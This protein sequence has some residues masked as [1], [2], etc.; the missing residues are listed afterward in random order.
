[1]DLNA[2]S[3]IFDKVTVFVVRNS[4][5]LA[6]I[7]TFLHPLAGRQI[8][9]GSVEQGEFPIDAAHR[10]VI[11]ETGFDRL[12]DFVA[13]GE[14]VET[15]DREAVALADTTVH[16]TAGIETDRIKRG[17]RVRIDRRDGACVLVR[18]LVY[19]FNTEPPIELPVTA[20]W[21]DAKDFGSQ[22][23]RSFFLASAKDGGHLS[24]V[25]HADGHEFSVEW[26]S[27]DQNLALVAGQD[28]W[29][30]AYFDKFKEHLERN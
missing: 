28:K 30:A 29:L 22:I 20:G 4:G 18:R 6:E 15:L 11:E 12:T 26:R 1:M 21:A 5:A 3:E 19:D 17:H 8:P 10:E 16:D 14:W 25:Q 2:K 13:I 24:W 9:A 7:L 27:L 23:R